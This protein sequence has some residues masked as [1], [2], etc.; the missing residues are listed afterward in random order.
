M[1]SYYEN[2]SMRKE[3]LVGYKVLE[4]KIVSFRKTTL[5]CFKKGNLNYLINISLRI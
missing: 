4:L 1:I 2:S 5:G 3:N